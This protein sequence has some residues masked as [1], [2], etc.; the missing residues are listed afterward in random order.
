[1]EKQSLIL[2]I[3]ISSIALS[4]TLGQNLNKDGGVSKKQETLRNLEGEVD[5]LNLY[6]NTDELIKEFKVINPTTVKDGLEKHIQ[7]RL[8]TGFANWNRGFETWK[9]WGNILYT[10]DS[11]YNVH[12]ARLTLEHYQEDMNETL[13]KMKI[14][15]GN[16]N[17][18][19]I[20]GDYCAIYYDILIRGRSGTTMEF[21]QFKDYGDATNPDVRVVEGWGGVKDDTYYDS[22]Q[23]QGSA[24]KKE[25]EEQNN[26]LLTYT[27]DDTIT[28]LTLKYFIKFPTANEDSGNVITKI[29]LEG[30]ES[31]NK[32]LSYYLDWVDN[33]FDENA[34]SSSMD[35]R[36]RNM[37]QYKAEITELFQN[38]TITKLY[39]DN[40]LI[41]D[42]WAAIHYRYRKENYK[43]SEKYVG[44]RMEFF[45]FEGE[46]QNLK[47]VAN[48]IQ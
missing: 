43:G 41:R 31:W 17:N 42:N 28:D 13:G 11:I 10:K 24:E 21:V 46:D 26:F 6:N 38:N 18:M 27:P 9:A 19:L 5:V 35:E 20:V 45:K 1:M 23:R 14:D 4:L 3:A 32:G 7:N 39:F 40:F 16:F 33:N 47:I 36:E 8:L 37:T 2:I 48:F 34:F 29:I 22:I 30:F 15:M 12:G 44:D 25:Q